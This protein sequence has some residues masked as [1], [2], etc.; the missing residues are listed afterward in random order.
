MRELDSLSQLFLK[1]QE[2]VGLA[3]LSFAALM[4]SRIYDS[5]ERIVLRD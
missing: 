1:E 2:K 4:E 5:Q 3:K